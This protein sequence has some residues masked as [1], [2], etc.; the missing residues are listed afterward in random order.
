MLI[1]YNCY[2]NKLLGKSK[3]EAG[4]SQQDFYA[5]FNKWIK[6]VIMDALEKSSDAVSHY[7]FLGDLQQI[8]RVFLI[9]NIKKLA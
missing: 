8:N 9:K 5:I 1:F 4:K 7:Y 6:S 3:G 2:R